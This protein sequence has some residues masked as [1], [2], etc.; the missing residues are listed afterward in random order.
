MGVSDWLLFMADAMSVVGPSI[1]Y[2]FQYNEMEL[3]KT[4]DGFAPEVCL[5]VMI[6][7]IARMYFWWVQRFAL[8]LLLQAALLAVSQ[9]ILLYQWQRFSKTRI[10]VLSSKSHFIKYS[11]LRS[12]CTE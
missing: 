2:G 7:M 3:K 8:P 12:H 10:P 6:S 11:I 4:S 9:V 1:G 5:I